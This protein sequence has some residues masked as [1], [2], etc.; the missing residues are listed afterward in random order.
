MALNI[1]F[2][3]DPISVVL[4]CLTIRRHRFRQILLICSELLNYDNTQLLHEGLDN[5]YFILYK[6]SN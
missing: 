1:Y 5:E 4:E 6:S 2:S 3:V